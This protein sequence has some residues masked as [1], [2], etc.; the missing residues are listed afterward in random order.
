MVAPTKKVLIA[1]AVLGL[2]GFGA[3]RLRLFLASEETRIRWL[4]ES[5]AD[6]FNE[7]DAGDCVAGL[8]EDF[9]EETVKL[10]KTE[11]HPLLVYLFFK[12]KD[13]KTG[14]FPFRIEVPRESLKVILG[15]EEGKASL[16]LLARFHE[17]RGKGSRLVW[18]ALITADLLK[19]DGAWRV[20]RSTH[21]PVS[22]KRPF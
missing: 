6:S 21:A 12:E 14:K 9:R 2:L 22:G 5:M 3:Y 13:P 17:D 11:I 8:A 4:V 1:L 10:G 18:E 15:P 7:R 20:A 16:E 19:K